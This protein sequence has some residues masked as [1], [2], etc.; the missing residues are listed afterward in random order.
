[1]KSRIGHTGWKPV[2][3]PQ[4]ENVFTGLGRSLCPAGQAEGFLLREG[5]LLSTGLD[6]FDDDLIDVLEVPTLKLLLNQALG[7]GL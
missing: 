6:P 2:A 5:L 7:F 4:L 3:A 1:M